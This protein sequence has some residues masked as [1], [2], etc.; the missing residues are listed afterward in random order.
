MTDFECALDRSVSADKPI[1]MFSAVLIDEEG[2]RRYFKSRRGRIFFERR[3]DLSNAMNYAFNTYEN[4]R[5]IIIEER[6]L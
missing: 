5:R 3:C 2:E 4:R 1:K 6:Y